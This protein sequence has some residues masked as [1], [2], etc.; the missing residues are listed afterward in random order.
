M[1]VGCGRSRRFIPG[2]HNRYCF[3]TFLLLCRRN[4]GFFF[5]LFNAFSGIRRLRRD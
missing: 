4:A 5:D 1:S 2:F 3:H